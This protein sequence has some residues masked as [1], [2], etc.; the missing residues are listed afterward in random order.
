LNKFGSLPANPVPPSV[1]KI[2]E[3]SEAVE[4]LIL[5]FLPEE[6]AGFAADVLAL[7]ECRLELI[8]AERENAT[9]H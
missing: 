5:R 4:P 3:L 1:D 7:R 9:L 2:I 6:A 8:E